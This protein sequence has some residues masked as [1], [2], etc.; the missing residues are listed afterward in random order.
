MSYKFE[1][2]QVDVELYR[3]ITIA[4]AGPGLA[5]VVKTIPADSSD[6]RI[7]D[8][9]RNW[10]QPEV[11]R[12]VLSIAVMIRNGIQ[13]DPEIFEADPPNH[14]M[15]AMD[16]TV[17]KLFP[18]VDKNPRVVKKDGGGMLISPGKDL[19]FRDALDKIIHAKHVRYVSEITF[20]NPEDDLAYPPENLTLFGDWKGKNPWEAD[21]Y[22]VDYALAA[23][24]LAP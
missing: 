24:R 20:S 9:L 8:W 11:S 6:R 4:V 22:L 2:A 7:L 14:Y 21:V 10:E 17:G 13:A 15:E 19:R 18:N 16:I 1:A 5:Q 23:A 12:L 3:L